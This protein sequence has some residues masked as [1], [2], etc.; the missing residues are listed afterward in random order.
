MFFNSLF[1]HN[2]IPTGL[3]DTVIVP[4]IKDKK[5]DITD[6][7]NYRPIALTCVLS[8]VLESLILFRCQCLL[9]TSSHQFG[10]K[11]KHG[12]DQ[13]VYVLQEVID[14]YY[15]NSSSPVYLCFMDASKAFDRVNHFC[16]LSKLLKRNIPVLI[17]RL[18][19]TWF[20]TQQFV[21][22]WLSC[23]SKPFHVKNGVRQGGVLSPILF[24][25]FMDNLSVELNKANIGCSIDTVFY[26][27][28]FYADDSVLIAPSPV[29][30]QKL[31]NICEEYAISNDILY[32]TKKPVCMCFLPKVLQNCDIPGITL[33]DSN[34]EWVLEYKYLGIFISSNLCDS[35]DI[36]RQLRSIYARGNTLVRKF[37]KCTDQVKLELF[38]SYCSNFYC[39]QLWSNYTTAMYNNIRVA[40]NNTFRFLMKIRGRHSISNSFV[41]SNIDGFT[42]IHRKSASSFYIRLVQSENILIKTIVSSVHFVTMSSRLGKTWKKLMF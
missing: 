13:C 1:T 22:K 24:N 20:S 19:L 10:F 38:R 42:V 15:H 16:L 7:D 8:K 6:C 18:L 3:L 26:N 27:H 14:F 34:L 21:V 41:Q 5:G 2:Y 25:V 37:G 30:L 11:A 23:I 12:T 9:S 4:L 40:Y 35:R 32:N 31:I 29:A 28:L 39:C 36:K 17:V 33:N